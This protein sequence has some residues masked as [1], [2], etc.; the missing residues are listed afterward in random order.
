MLNI[1]YHNRR[2][3]SYIISLKA[4][5]A[6]K[7]FISA[8][9]DIGRILNFI[10][11]WWNTPSLPTTFGLEILATYFVKVLTNFKKVGRGCYTPHTHPLETPLVIA[12]VCIY[13]KPTFFVYLVR[14]PFWIAIYF[15]RFF[16]NLFQ[17]FL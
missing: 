5:I 13:R 1:R 15:D 16:F 7:S 9:L 3:K 6:D 14:Y 17:L 11:L 2:Y 12:I 8:E 4:I 10:F